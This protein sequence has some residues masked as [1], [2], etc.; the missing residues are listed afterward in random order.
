MRPTNVALVEG[1]VVEEYFVNNYAQDNGDHEVHTRS[2]YWRHM[3][4]NM[5]SLGVF[6]KCQDAVKAAKY[7]F[8]QADG[9]KFCCPECHY[10]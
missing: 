7:I 10:S 3:G 2:C 4:E 9:C 6:D 5:R 8:P 1:E